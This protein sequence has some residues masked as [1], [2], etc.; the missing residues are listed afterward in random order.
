MEVPESYKCKDQRKKFKCVR[1]AYST[2][3]ECFKNCVKPCKGN[4]C[5]Y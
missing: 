1:R 4:R 3:E 2:N 5:V